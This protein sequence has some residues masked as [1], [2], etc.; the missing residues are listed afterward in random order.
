MRGAYRS[1]QLPTQRRYNGGSQT[2]PRVA[3]DRTRGDL[4]QAETCEI[5][6]VVGNASLTTGPK[7]RY[8]KKIRNEHVVHLLSYL[9]NGTLMRKWDLVLRCSINI[10]Y[11]A[12]LPLMTMLW[13]PCQC[14]N[15]LNSI[16][17]AKTGFIENHSE[18]S[19]L[20]C[21]SQMYNLLVK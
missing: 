16:T 10:N 9:D 7:S 8:E 11:L 18:A 17:I 14:I 2:L 19:Q 20:Y 21:I 5:G 13:K 15:N 3:C 1:L 12:F 6:K 4:T